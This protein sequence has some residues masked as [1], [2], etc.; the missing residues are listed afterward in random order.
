VKVHTGTVIRIELGQDGG[1]RAEIA[2]PQEL[3]PAPGQ[4]IQSHKRGDE[5]TTVPLSLFLSRWRG[6]NTST[7]TAAPP[8]PLDWQPGDALILRAPLGNGFNIPLKAK[9]IGLVALSDTTARLLPLAEMSIYKRLEVALFTDAPLPRL[10]SQIE[11]NPLHA[12]PD[13]ISWSD[14]LAFDGAPVEYENIAKTMGLSPTSP[15]PCPAQALVYLPMPCGGLGEC[16]VCAVPGKGR[17]HKLA[18]MDG[19]VFEWGEVF[20]SD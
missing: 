17:K 15:L 13:A 6:D 5:T 19:P 1:R 11:A 12:L 14:Y 7:F 8:I 16:G 9:R 10:S 3:I 2:C 4:Y 18:C 20:L